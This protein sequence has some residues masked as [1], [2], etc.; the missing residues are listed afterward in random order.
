MKVYSVE[1]LEEILKLPP[2]QQDA[3]FKKQREEMEA[4]AA[5][6]KEATERE[7]AEATEHFV[8]LNGNDLTEIIKA[9]AKGDQEAQ[10]HIEDLSSNPETK[11]LIIMLAEIIELKKH[12]GDDIIKGLLSELG[13]KNG[14]DQ[15]EA[16]PKKET[17]RTAAKAGDVL[18]D[19]PANLAT[20]TFASYDNAMSLYQGGNAY[21]MPLPGMDGLKFE[22]GKLYFE[23]NLKPI[24]EAELQVMRTKENIS[25]VN[26][27]LLRSLYTLIG[28]EIAN[29]VDPQTLKKKN[30]LDV[31]ELY[32][33]DLSA[34][35]G[36]GRNP[37]KDKI[38]AI[39]KEVQQFHNIVG[40]FKIPYG[41]DKVRENIFPVLNFEGY[42][43]EKNT[44]LFSSPYMNYVIE[45][46]LELSIRKDAKGKPKLKKNNEPLRLPT[47][48]YAIK[49]EI[50]KER[51][52]NAVEN[53]FI[54][55]TTI[56]QAGGKGAHLAASTI[57][58]R[59]EQLKQALESSANPTQL[60]QRCF[61][62][63]W[64]LLRTGTRLTELYEDIQLPDPKDPA[65][66]PTASTL[67]KMV[68]NFPHKGKVKG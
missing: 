31:I 38:T 9:A 53:V 46:L 66:I 1:E 37:N 34:Y 24:T 30:K 14:S 33:P 25:S 42:N 52:K 20:I 3:I 7:L 32:I 39:I 51:N 55:V 11:E 29:N 59:N 8:T 47:H 12:Y 61:K 4:E 36:K 56:E 68:F 64:E 57:V 19:Y 65:N 48:S 21:L 43:E 2:E 22:D 62:K 26:L 44:I 63:T 17:Y 23:G 58:E 13:K 49:S 60:L 18:Q 28:R 15:E 5:A 35:L 50:V 67:S 45:R 54:I 27:P 16:E 40:I 41:G 10:G 6:A